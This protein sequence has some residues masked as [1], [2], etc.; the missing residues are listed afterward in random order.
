[1]I[2]PRYV[3]ADGPA[4]RTLAATLELTDY[5]GRTTKYEYGV[6]IY[7]ITLC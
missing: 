5:F 4:R 1:M 6:L 3:P 2:L 7:Q